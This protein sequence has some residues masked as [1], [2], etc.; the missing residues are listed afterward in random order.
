M[1]SFNAFRDALAQVPDITPVYTYI[2]GNDTEFEHTAAE[3]KSLLGKNVFSGMWCFP[4]GTPG[5]IDYPP[6][7]ERLE[8]VRWQQPNHLG[9]EY[10]LSGRTAFHTGDDLNIPGYADIG[11]PVRS[12]TVGVVTYADYVPNSTWGNVLVIRLDMAGDSFFYTRFGHLNSIEVKPGE[13][14]FPGQIVAYV[15]NVGMPTSPHLHW[16]I[17]KENDPLLGNSPLNWPW[18][19]K[20]FVMAHYI[21]PGKFI[22]NHVNPQPIPE[23]WWRR[24]TSGLRAR[25]APGTTYATKTILNFGVR[26]EV[27]KN[28]VLANTYNWAKVV[29]S[30]TDTA[31]VGC[32]VAVEFL[33]PDT[34]PKPPSPPPVSS[35]TLGIHVAYNGNVGDLMGVL[36]RANKAG[37]PVPFVLVVS[38]PGL[39]SAIK[40]VS[41]QTIV[42]YRW[43]AGDEDP[44]P[45]D[46][47]GN[48][49]GAAWV[50]NLMYRHSQA[51]EA[52]YHQFFNEV[53]F[54]GNGQSLE[55]A[56][57]VARVEMDMCRT[58]HAN[59]PGFKMTGGNYMP[60]VPDPFKY[61]AELKPLYDMLN[62][63]GD[64]A[65][66][67]W[68]STPEADSS[69]QNGATW[70]CTRILDYFDQWPNMPVFIGEMGLYNSPR[71]RG[72]DSERATWR[73][74]TNIV[75]PYRTRGRK[76]WIA[77]WTIRGQDSFK[78]RPDDWTPH[79][80]V[81]E[82]DLNS[83][84]LR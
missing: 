15:G 29:S 47:N 31:A 34:D 79:L 68:Y 55:Y 84:L 28:T 39:V 10:I 23:T 46:I 83:G 42:I 26:V 13:T 17:T 24:T 38:D 65:L 19:D 11:E 37:N 63:N 36:D 7:S 6:Y 49:D 60:G 40:R 78:W 72:V 41:P 64:A 57:N 30:P 14:V 20:A 52:D 77:S 74:T 8:D 1:D 32:Y 73:D 21:D 50:H 82:A 2:A 71:F 43:V 33:G 56:R 58:L 9:M 75:R 59:Y 48:G 62:A 3:F 66:F 5:A 45:F 25:I 12:P 18:E 4:V 27:E 76:I 67:H 53:S 61:G 80:N 70:M 22:M 69:M 51:P 44:S 16:D 81:Y 35:N 54:S